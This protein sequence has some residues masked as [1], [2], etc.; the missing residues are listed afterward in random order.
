MSGSNLL[1]AT[2]VSPKVLYSSQ[3]TTTADVAIYTVGAG[4]SAVIKH[5]TVCNTSGS[6]ATI[7]LKI[8]PSGGSVDGT[9]AVVSAYSLAAG[10]TLSLTGYL[11]GCCLGPGDSIHAQAGTANVLDVIIT[12]TEN[13]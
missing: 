3:L 2:A 5:G 6:A 7:T 10:D 8:I 13:A 4:L 1:A 11:T 12:G 9:H